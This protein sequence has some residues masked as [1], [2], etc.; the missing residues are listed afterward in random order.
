[1][2]ALPRWVTLDADV[3]LSEGRFRD[4]DPAGDRIPGA[5]ER[6]VAAGVT[7]EDAGPIF[8]SVRLR[9]FGARDLVEDG[10][11]RSAPTTLVNLQAGVKLGSRVRV[12]GDVFNLLNREVS[13]IDYYYAS[14]LASEPSPVD[15][16]HFHPALP[17]TVRI[18]LNVGF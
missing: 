11:V 4:D 15:D 16:I 7:I 14:R 13:D 18:G 10:S 3:S 12:I 1:L 5:V 6:V 8:G 9:Y 2:Y 17:R